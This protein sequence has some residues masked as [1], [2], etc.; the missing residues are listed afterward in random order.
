L[1]FGIIVSTRL[2]LA[3][4]PAVY[5]AAISRRIEFICVIEL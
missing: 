4:I 1:T 3:T 5:Y 2:I